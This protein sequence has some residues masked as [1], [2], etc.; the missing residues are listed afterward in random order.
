MVKEY[1]VIQV[2]DDDRSYVWAKGM[3]VPSLKEFLQYFVDSIKQEAIDTFYVAEFT[4]DKIKSVY[5]MQTALAITGIK[6]RSMAEKL[7]E[8]SRK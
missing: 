5:K 4:D 7:S 2:V 3:D 6:K 1:Q 8:G